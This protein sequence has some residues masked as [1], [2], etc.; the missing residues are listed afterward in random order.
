MP[1][2]LPARKF[3]PSYVALILAVSALWLTGLQGCENEKEPVK[4]KPAPS[5]AQVP[6]KTDTE[7]LTFQRARGVMSVVR[8]YHGRGGSYG[9]N[10]REGFSMYPERSR[11]GLRKVILEKTAGWELAIE[12]LADL[13]PDGT[14]KSEAVIRKVFNQQEYGTARAEAAAALGKLKVTDAGPEILAYIKTLDPDK[15][16]RKM[17]LAAEG[18]GGTRPAG[19]TDYILR[20]LGMRPLPDGRGVGPLAALYGSVEPEKTAVLGALTPLL[21]MP[22]DEKG[23]VGAIRGLGATEHPLALEVL[24]KF[25]SMYESIRKKN[26][27]T[28]IRKFGGAI[29]AAYGEIARFNTEVAWEVILQH[30]DS[31]YT[32]GYHDDGRRVRAAAE[33][34]PRE[35][36]R[37]KAET[38]GKIPADS[39]AP[40][41]KRLRTVGAVLLADLLDPQFRQKCLHQIEPLKA[42]TR[43]DANISK[44]LLM[45]TPYAKAGDKQVIA[46]CREYAATKQPARFTSRVSARQ[47][48]QQCK[49]RELIKILM[50][51]GNFSN[52]SDWS[53]VRDWE[54]TEPVAGLSDAFVANKHAEVSYKVKGTRHPAVFRALAA[55]SRKDVY[56]FIINWIQTA[57]NNPKIDH[58][59]WI[60]GLTDWRDP[61]VNRFLYDL[62]ETLKKENRQRPINTTCAVLARR[63]DKEMIPKMYTRLL[64]LPGGQD[65]GVRPIL[66]KLVGKDYGPFKADGPPL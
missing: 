28:R 8:Q 16:A 10:A 61:E 6:E 5:K 59:S 45:L 57:L 19:T 13:G 58:A 35:F 44:L 14:G 29:F 52:S 20:L 48:L 37:K 31:G 38:W 25:V 53:R 47:I 51:A 7:K 11:V 34:I 9:E 27:L 63:G 3:R 40:S 49:D 17:A 42:D 4:E 43:Y 32:F 23:W 62:I 15:D 55:E 1:P 36:V 39:K 18:L 33:K 60:R 64:T 2:L 22:W 66:E 24:L 54:F 65:K 56:E 12:Y 46:L 30:N 50:A 26:D 41:S 21:F